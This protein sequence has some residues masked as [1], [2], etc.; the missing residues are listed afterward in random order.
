MATIDST[1]FNRL[2]K[3]L[4]DFMLDE[5]DRRAILRLALNDA[6]VYRRIRFGGAADTFTVQMLSELLHYGEISPGKPAVSALLDVLHD[7]VG[8]NQQ[9]EI[10]QWQATLHAQLQGGAAP[11]LPDAG[12]PVSLTTSPTGRRAYYEKSWAVVIGI[13]DYRGQHRTLLNAGNDARSMAALLH[14]RGFEQVYTL[15]D[16][17]ATRGAIMT[18]LRDS[19]PQQ[20]GPEDRVVFFFAG[21]GVT[22]S[23]PHN[24][25]RGYLVPYNSS[26]YAD[27]IDMEELRQACSLM[28]AKHILLL[29]DCCFSGVAAVMTRST[30]T[31]P[32]QLVNDTFLA[33]VT[34]R[35]AWQILTA[36]A[37]DQQ[38]ADSGKR[39]GHSAFT[40]ALLDG[41]AGAADHDH[42]GIITATSLAN[43]VIPVVARE[44]AVVGQLGQKPVFNYLAGSEQGDFVFLLP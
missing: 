26:T 22:Q 36:G 33:E 5:A 21:H 17:A 32:T 30:L 10:D 6:A 34:R 2:A 42:D 18:W 15:Y 25:K 11:T 1:T 27:Y 7:R 44:T 35:G 28:K 4:T 9:R 12:R 16:Q 24:S 20:T 8:V 41:L 40:S 3:F 39:P 13:N 14:Q 23:G 31:I 43:Y 38:A 19:L 29:L 37:E